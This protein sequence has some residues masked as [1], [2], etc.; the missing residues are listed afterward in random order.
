MPEKAGVELNGVKGVLD[1]MQAL[2]AKLSTDGNPHVIVGFTASYAM[3]VHER[4][5]PTLMK[6]KGFSR[7]P[8]IRRIEMGG[9]PDKAR[10]RPRKREPHGMFWDPQDKA[11]PK[12]L[13]AP[14]QQLRD[15]G[16]FTR[17][18]MTALKSNQTVAQAM[19]Q[20]G[21]R[22]QREA[23]LRV[24]VDTG[25]LKGSAFTRLELNGGPVQESTGGEA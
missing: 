13:E 20:C 15:E 7:D 21:L 4:L 23:M 3:A 2:T 25:N 19:L 22:L 17:I 12:F 8:R 18:I 24:P 9:D 11:G 10:P 6:W 5:G 16:E 14:A 1:K